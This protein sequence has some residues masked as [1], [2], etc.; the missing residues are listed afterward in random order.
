MCEFSRLNQTTLETKAHTHPLHWVWFCVC[1]DFCC[2]SDEAWSC[3]AH[4]ALSDTH[5]LVRYTQPRGWL[6]D[7]HTWHHRLVIKPTCLL[8]SSPSLDLS[9]SLAGI[10]SLFLSSHDFV[11]AF[12]FLFVYPLSPSLVFSLSPSQSLSTTSV[13]PLVSD[14][15]LGLSMGFAVKMERDF[16]CQVKNPHVDVCWPFMAK[17]RFYGHSLAEDLLFVVVMT[18][19]TVQIVVIVSCKLLEV[20][21]IHLCS[22]S[23]SL[24]WIL[25]FSVFND[26]HDF[27]YFS[28]YFM[29]FVLYSILTYFSLCTSC[30][31]LAQS[32]C[33]SMYFCVCL[34]N[35]KWGWGMTF[36]PAVTLREVCSSKAMWK[37]RSIYLVIFL[38][39]I[40][41]T[42]QYL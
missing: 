31:C 1:C 8:P 16:D 34:S 37:K 11:S 15:S 38:L 18:C 35:E 7:I 41:S 14:L 29:Q 36:M 33:T 19:C 22:C 27:I 28:W 13:F 21:L 32:R 5:M 40:L 20:G 10:L 39:Q 6:P 2:T 26:L 30:P 23:P 4:S 12:L 42:V 17:I 3:P 24:T 25:S 9:L